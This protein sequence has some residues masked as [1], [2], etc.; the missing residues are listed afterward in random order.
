MTQQAEPRGSMYK[1]GDAEFEIIR[2]TIDVE[3]DVVRQHLEKDP[4]DTVRRFLVSRGYT[5]NSITAPFP[6]PGQLYH[7]GYI[8]IVSGKLQSTWS[9]IFQ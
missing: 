7:P 9:P 6:Q 8:H 3:D 2:V 5:V 4:A 1:V